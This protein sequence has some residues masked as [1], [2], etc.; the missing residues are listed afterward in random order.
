VKV[1]LT[2]AK[3]VKEGDKATFYL[4][5]GSASNEGFEAEGDAVVD[6]PGGAATLKGAESNKAK[7]E[8]DAQF[9]KASDAV[10]AG[11]V[12]RVD[13]APSAEIREHAPDLRHATVQ[14]SDVAKGDIAL[15]GQRVP[16]L[17]ANSEDVQWYEAPKLNPSDRGT[18]ALKRRENVTDARTKAHVAAAAASIPG[19]IFTAL[20]PRS[21][22]KQN[23]PVALSSAQ[24]AVKVDPRYKAL[25][26]GQ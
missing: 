4:Y 16:V 20:D 6:R 12:I 25:L 26:S 3:S 10:V 24:I 7:D 21:F 15:V 13:P 11:V 2:D 17:F 9:L 23:A 22:V 18:F 8:A 19:T 14:I 1:D 5:G